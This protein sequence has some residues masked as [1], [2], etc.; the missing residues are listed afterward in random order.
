MIFGGDFGQS[1]VLTGGWGGW[2]L[3]V[4]DRMKG[5]FPTRHLKNQKINPTFQDDNKSRNWE[6]KLPINP[7][8]VLEIN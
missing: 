6:P 2:G 5:D 3:G 1:L 7:E 8:V 4:R